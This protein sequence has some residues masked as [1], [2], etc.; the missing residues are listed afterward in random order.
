MRALPQLCILNTAVAALI[1]APAA[2][3]DAGGYLGCL[4]LKG[5]SFDKPDK[6]VAM[7]HK[8]LTNIQSGTQPLTVVADLEQGGLS[9]WAAMQ[10]YQ[11]SMIYKP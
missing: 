5:I 2:H 3:A 10:V 4:G 11:C 9:Q 7:G 6:E 8:V 1:L